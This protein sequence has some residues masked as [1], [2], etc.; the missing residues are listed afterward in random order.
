[1][2]HRLVRGENRHP[3]SIKPPWAG[4]MQ[5]EA[6]RNPCREPSGAASREAFRNIL[7]SSEDRK[8]VFHAPVT[9]LQE[10]VYSAVTQKS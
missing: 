8:S 4:M 2:R 9:K 1:M 3:I 10:V 5:H 6:R 7:A